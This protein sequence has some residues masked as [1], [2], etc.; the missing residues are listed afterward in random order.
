MDNDSRITETVVCLYTYSSDNH[1]TSYKHGL[2]KLNCNT[3][4]NSDT[5]KAGTFL[6]SSKFRGLL[7]GKVDKV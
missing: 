2:I 6:E 3:L 5:E 4:V 1:L 7:D